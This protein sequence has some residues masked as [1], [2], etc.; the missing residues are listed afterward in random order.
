MRIAELVESLDL[1]Q[2]QVAERAWEG[3]RRR[4]RRR[5]GALAAGGAAVA[6]AC[7]I[8]LT[9]AGRSGDATTPTPAPSPTRTVEPRTAPLVQRLLI[10]KQLRKVIPNI[11]FQRFGGHPEQAVPLST[12]PVDRAAIAMA[13]YQDDA[14]ALVL[15]EDGEWRRVDVPGLVPVRDE[16]G[17]TS[18]IVRPTSLSPDDTKLALPQPNALVVVDLTDGTS[19]RYDVP[20]EDN[21]YVIWD[22]KSHV[23]VARETAVHGTMVDLRDGSLSATRY[24]PY[25]RFADGA[26]LTWTRHRD[27]FLKSVL[28][29]DDGRT[30][31]TFAGN[32]GSALTQPPLVKGDIVVGVG[33]GYHGPQHLPENGSGIFVMDGSTGEV[34]AD[35]T[36]GNQ[37]LTQTTLFGWDGDRPIVGV[38]LPGQPDA[39]AAFAWD[40]RHGEVESEGVVGAWTSWGTG[41]VRE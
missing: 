37:T 32:D 1:P 39:L 8:G 21:H 19:R 35:L 27:T 14:T 6:V 31:E 3:G 24:G 20:G 11:D 30:V 13:S 33:A 5:R 34:L 18:P 36:L 25:T 28:H 40:W 7:V 38:P 22:G 17:Y 23:I 16:S 12:H 15:G 2:T 29:W 41:Q 4:V 9:V 10:G 26:V